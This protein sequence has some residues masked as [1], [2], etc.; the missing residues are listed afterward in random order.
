MTSISR[1]FQITPLTDTR[2]TIT[3][4]KLSIQNPVESDEGAYQCQAENQ[5]GRIISPPVSIDF[6]C[7]LSI[8]HPS[9]S[10]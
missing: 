2:Y 10:Y 9:A 4:G 8:E 3:N 1:H 5:F 6:G 7:K